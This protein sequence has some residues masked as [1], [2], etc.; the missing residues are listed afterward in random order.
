MVAAV[1]VPLYRVYP[2]SRVN[3]NAR[4]NSSR[5]VWSY[6]NV[7]AVDPVVYRS[8]SGVPTDPNMMV[9]ALPEVILS[10]LLIAF[11]WLVVRPVKLILRADRLP[12]RRVV[13][14]LPL[15]NPERAGSYS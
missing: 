1:N 12:L 14:R 4:M 2:A 13:G 10:A 9:A 15:P 7:E 3:P 11:C 6:V 5:L 8:S